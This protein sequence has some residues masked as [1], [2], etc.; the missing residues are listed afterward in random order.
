MTSTKRWWKTG[1]KK[2]AKY[3]C[4]VPRLVKCGL[5]HD[6]KAKVCQKCGRP[7]QGTK[8]RLAF[9]FWRKVRKTQGCWLWIGGRIKTNGYGVFN[10]TDRK[11]VAHHVSWFLAH[12]KWPTSGLE[13]DHLC[14]VKNCVKPKHLEMVTH[15]E[16]MRRRRDAHCK[17]GHKQTEA[18]RYYYRNS[19]RS[20]CRP[21]LQVICDERKAKRRER[22]LKKPGRKAMV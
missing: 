4:H 12:G 18:N 17:R 21:C 20:R 14:N 15:K 3:N 5:K 16:N 2:G 19:T 11:R 22:G 9:N 7:K 13:T 8:A 6:W 10:W 1:P